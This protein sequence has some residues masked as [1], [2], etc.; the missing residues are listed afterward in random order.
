MRLATP[1]ESVLVLARGNRDAALTVDLLARQNISAFVCEDV[2]SLCL[3]LEES[4]GAALIA[5]EVLTDAGIDRITEYLSLQPPWSD[6]PFIIFTG[7]PAQ[8][9]DERWARLGNVS[10]LERPVR[11]RAMIA[12]VRAALRGRRRQYDARRAIEAR[13]QFLAM[14]GHELRNPLAAVR[15]ATALISGADPEAVT[16]HRLVIERQTQHLTRL[17]DDLLDV[18][19]VTYGKVSLRPEPLYLD[20]VIRA[21]CQSLAQSFHASGLSLRLDLEPGL[22]VVGDRVRLEQIFANLLHNAIK[23]TPHGGAVELEARAV[24]GWA[25]VR[26]RDSGIGLDREMFQRVFELFAQVDRSLDRAQG[27]LGLGLT[28]VRA[29]VQLHGGRV[30]AE[31]A[32]LGRGS[33]FRVELPI[34]KRGTTKEEHRPLARPRANAPLRVVVVED[35]EDIRDMLKELLETEGHAVSIAGDG[36][37]G[38]ARILEA[39]PDIAFIDIGL[40]EFDGYEV[41]RQVRANGSPTLLVALT[42]YGQREDRLH[43]S[44]AGF[45]R[46][47]TK[48]VDLEEL[49]STMMEVRP[50]VREHPSPRLG[51]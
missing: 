36:P 33:E 18:A 22:S 14:L 43:A 44:E 27:G 50:V 2:R 3:R 11:V 37:T 13:D 35:G 12:S 51:A 21:C 20:E 31:S 29:L 6:F 46:H 34:T 47:L 9:D 23:Y 8:V 48:P 1:S 4:A 7:A 17:I 25:V 5:E 30:H 38:V 42:G 40:P 41:A 26:V 49:Y 15:L 10:I 45:D 16:R 32:G 19:R 28:L 24:K 39:K